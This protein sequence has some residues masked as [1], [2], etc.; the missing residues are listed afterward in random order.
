MVIKTDAHC[1]KVNRYVITARF[2]ETKSLS[3]G[4][5]V[6]MIA[7]KTIHIYTVQESSVFA[8]FHPCMKLLLRTGHRESQQYMRE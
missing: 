8:M 1:S 7:M 4:R 3:H 6:H 5:V 2:K